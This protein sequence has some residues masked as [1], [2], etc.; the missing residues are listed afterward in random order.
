MIKNID[1]EYTTEIVCPYCGCDFSDSYEHEP[2]NEDIGLIDCTSC[3][4]SFYATRNITIDYCTEKATKG[5]CSIC[6]KEDVVIED[7]RQCGFETKNV[8]VEC[9]QSKE[10][11]RFWGLFTEQ[12]NAKRLK[13]SESK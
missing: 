3:D 4:E 5:T 7:T 11:A 10:Q 9:C 8:G 13:G 12:Q 1:H 2:G 6:G